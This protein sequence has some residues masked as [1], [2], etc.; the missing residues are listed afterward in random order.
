[1]ITRVEA[2]HYRALRHINQP[3]VPFQVLIGPNASGK[4]TFLDIIA[5]ISDIVTRPTL[6]DA[7]IARATD[8]RDLTW[9]RQHEW[10]ELAVE[11][12]IP[13]GLDKRY[14]RVRYEIRLGAQ[15]DTS[16]L[17]IL[18]ENL[19]L[20]AAGDRPDTSPKQRRLFPDAPPVPVR[21]TRETRKKTLA[22]WRR[23]VS[24]TETGNDYFRSESTAWNNQFRLGPQ[25]S[26]LAN[27]L[28]VQERFPVSTWFKR[29][30]SEGVQRLVLNSE[31]MRRPSL[32]QSPRAFLPDGSNLP[33][34]VWDLQTNHPDQLQKW[35]DHIRTA[36]PDV[37]SIDTFEREEDRYRYL[38]LSYQ[39]G[40][41]A[42][43]WAISD[44]TLRLLALTIL[45]YLPDLRGTYLV[46]EPENG[47]HPLAVET[48]YQS[49]SSVYGAQVLLATHSPV[50]LSLT[51][52][53][54]LL[55]FARTDEGQ[56]DIVRG[57][58]HPRLSEWQREVD[59]STLFA[60]G[61]LG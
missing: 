15:A 27:L 19:W 26:A 61:V 45:A 14:S 58:Q 53:G 52:P 24:K 2:L 42:P 25:R 7:V 6:R 22:G 41:K 5:F 13:A 60:S 36:L 47:I 32:P 35:V 16:E 56:T 4:T 1:M 48:V 55:C 18:V 31:A 34:V 57:D 49:L 33:W 51:E 29:Y 9:M 59:I 37:H 17:G 44:G 8:F 12:E 21:I 20:M 23:V 50:I 11:A 30:I 54:D 3:L 43:S 10:L 39:T 28:E 40:L 38:V 46:E